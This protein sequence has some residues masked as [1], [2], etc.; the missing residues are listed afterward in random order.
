MELL[1]RKCF[2]HA[3]YKYYYTDDDLSIIHMYNSKCSIKINSISIYTYKMIYVC[4]CIQCISDIPAK[5]FR[6]VI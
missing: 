3:V 4:T 5:I 1:F 6:S 2:I